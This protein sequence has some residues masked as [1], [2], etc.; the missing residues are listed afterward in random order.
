[1]P[2]TREEQDRLVDFLRR[3]QCGPCRR[4]RIDPSHPGCAEA[5]DL[6]EIVRR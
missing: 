2:M 5:E 1:M 4:G 3:K 6:I